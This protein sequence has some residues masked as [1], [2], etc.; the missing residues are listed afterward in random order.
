MLLAFMHSQYR[1]YCAPNSARPLAEA[2]RSID[3]ELFDAYSCVLLESHRFNA[4][5]RPMKPLRSGL[6]MAFDAAAA[7]PEIYGRVE[8]ILVKCNERLR[9]RLRLLLEQDQPLLPALMAPA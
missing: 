2:S 4:R 3:P 7:R 8:R 1:V 6:F 9:G 5:L